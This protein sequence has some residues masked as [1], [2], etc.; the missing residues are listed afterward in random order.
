MCHV[1]ELA[2]RLRAAGYEP[3]AT[4]SSIVLMGGKGTRLAPARKRIDVRAL[5]GMDPRFDGIEGPK[6]LAPLAA[7]AS[8]G[9][10]CKPIGDWHLDLH[11]TCPAVRSVL[12][13]IGAAGEVVLAYYRDAR[14]SRY[15]GLPLSFLVEGRPA[16]T[17]AP[18]V[19]LAREG[20]LPGTPLVYANG[21][22]LIDVDFH[23]AYLAGCVRAV[24]AGLDPADCVIDVAALVPWEVSSEYGTLDM[25]FATGRV[26]AFREKAPVAKN[27]YVELDGVKLT[28]INSGFSIVP[29]PKRLFERYL[30]AEIMQL[31]ADLEAGKL[32]YKGTESRV[33]YETLYG[34]VAA[35]GRMLGVYRPGFWADLGTEEKIL[36]AEEEL[37][38]SVLFERLSMSKRL[39]PTGTNSFHE[40]PC[41]TM[42]KVGRYLAI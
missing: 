30:T 15:R 26:R 27:P 31:S 25:D 29:N 7:R 21:D 19:K 20:R 14:H 6:V 42:D 9:V 40:G 17:L 18:I 24:E 8:G 11:A 39:A 22:N 32:D 41:S 37:P 33:K 35:D 5:P 10:V 36:R 1:D 28:P 3:S 13:A 4:L 23:R 2:H 38:R 12:L 34:R 16:G